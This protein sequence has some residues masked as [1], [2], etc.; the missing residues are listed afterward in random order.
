MKLFEFEQP[1][2]QISNQEFDATSKFFRGER[3]WYGGNLKNQLIS[4]LRKLGWRPMGRGVFSMVFENFQKQYVLKVTLNPDPG[5]A[6]YV[7]IIKDN[8]NVHFPRIS[9]LK[10]MNIDGHEFYVYLIE[11]LK[12]IA[13]SHRA[14]IIA[15]LLSWIARGDSPSEIKN[16][17]FNL[18]W[19]PDFE[20]ISNSED[21]MQAIVL[22]G[23]AAR[24]HRFVLDIHQDN[25]MI[26]PDGTVVITDPYVL[27]TKGNYE[28]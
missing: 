13:D 18:E 20:E 21:L 12:P 15:N 25:I 9:D 1:D 8:P 4:R 26:R 7:K 14:L 3:P 16:M 27:N 22:V 6:E 5:Y 17:L 28:T 2:E 19:F 11:R 23:N 24:Q 10:S